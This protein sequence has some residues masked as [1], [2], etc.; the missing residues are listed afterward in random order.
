MHCTL[1]PPT[2]D[3]CTENLDMHNLPDGIFGRSKH[4]ETHF[5]RCA[6]VQ[7]QLQ[8]RHEKICSQAVFTI[9]VTVYQRQVQQFNPNTSIVGNVRNL[10]T[11]LDLDEYPSPFRAK[12]VPTSVLGILGSRSFDVCFDILGIV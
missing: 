1:I 6:Q 4:G 10:N 7:Q 11:L 5:Q 8:R 12:C 3:P 2:E 9:I